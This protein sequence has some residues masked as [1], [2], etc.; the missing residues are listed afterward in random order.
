M[1]G[2]FDNTVV[3]VT[4]FTS[5]I[6]RAVAEAFAGAGGR[7]AGIGRSAEKGAEVVGGIERA[8]GQAL[9]FSADVADEG[10]VGSAVAA[11]VDRWGPVRVLVNAAGERLTG[12]TTDIT[13]AQWRRVLETNLT[14]CFITSRAVIPGMA[15]AGGGAIIHVSANSGFR[16]T[17]GRVAYSASKGA[18]HNLTE[19]MAQDHGGDNIRVNCIAPGPTQTPMLAGIPDELRGKLAARVPLGRIGEPQQIAQA[20]LFLAS[21]AALHITGAILAVNGGSHLTL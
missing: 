1:S 6:G 5:G 8:G 11:V 14:G 10:A 4:G 9:F 16:G 13:P 18:L 3:L 15:A 2:S 19:A 7:V 17:A 21:D 12:S 20:A